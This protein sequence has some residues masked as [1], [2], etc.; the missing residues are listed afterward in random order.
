AKSAQ[1][2]PHVWLPDA[3]KSPTPISS[4]TRVATMRFM[5]KQRELNP[6]MGDSQSTALVDLATSVL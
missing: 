4:L 2:P 5:G 3:M 6:R 1:F